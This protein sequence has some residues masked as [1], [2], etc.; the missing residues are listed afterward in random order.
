MQLSIKYFFILLLGIACTQAVQAQKIKRQLKGFVRDSITGIPI[1]NTIIS[2]ETTHKMTT[3]DGKGFFSITALPGDVIFINAFNYSF[4]TLIAGNRTPDTLQID[5][6][7]IPEYLPGVTVTTTQGYSRYQLDSLRRRETFVKDV[8]G[9]KMKTASKADNMGAG[10]AINLDKFLS[11]RTK[12]RTKAY[13]T[14]DKLETNAYID[15][16]FSPQTVAQYTGLHGDSLAA[17]MQRYTPGYDW[18]RT[19]PTNE[20][21]VYYIN[22]KLK[23]FGDKPKGE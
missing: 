23:E 20:D 1:T 5:L 9:P 2:N 14:F 22:E 10:V 16:R 8:G 12:D 17:F 4:D 7:R 13:N 11:K 19:H 3:P 15:Y 6:T 18:L 21:V